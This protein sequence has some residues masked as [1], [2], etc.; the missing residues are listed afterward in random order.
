MYILHSSIRL[1]ENCGQ[2]EEKTKAV[3]TLMAC[4][5]LFKRMK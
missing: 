4:N 5:Q 1:N 3:Y 2:S